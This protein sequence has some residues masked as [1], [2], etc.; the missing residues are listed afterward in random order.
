MEPA[1]RALLASGN[2]PLAAVGPLAKLSDEDRAAAAPLFTKLSWSRSN[3]VNILTWLF[4]TAKMTDSPVREVMN[5]AG[6]NAILGQGLSPKDAIARLS[7]AARQ[8]RYPELSRLQDRFVSAAGE[9]TTG[10]RWRMAQPNNFET[11]GSELTVQVKDAD[12]LAQAVR[13]LERLAASPAWE[14]IWNLGSLNDA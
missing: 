14:K 9:I 12:Q 11:G 10:T 4:E 3:G 1:W 13:D 2:A 5:R 6:M 8:A 7:A